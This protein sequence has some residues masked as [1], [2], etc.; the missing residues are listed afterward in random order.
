MDKNILNLSP[1]Q[2][3]QLSSSPAARELMQLLQ[4]NHAD[5]MHEAMTGAQKGDQAAVKQSLSAL[6][7]DPRTR[8]LLKQ[9][10][11]AQNGR[12]GR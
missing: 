10:Q 11:E 7:S 3:R 12:D 6:L 8:Q 4:S 9:L 5:A 1:E 2:M